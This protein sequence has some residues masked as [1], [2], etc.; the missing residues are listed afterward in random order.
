[1]QL[2]SGTH[3][4]HCGLATPQ[5]QRTESTLA[6]VMACCLTAQRHYL[7]QCW[8]IINKILWHSS[9]D[10]IMRRHFYH[11]N[12]ISRTAFRSP[13]ANELKTSWYQ[14]QLIHLLA[15]VGTLLVHQSHNFVAKSEFFI[16]I[17][18]FFLPLQMWISAM[19]PVFWHFRVIYVTIRLLNRDHFLS[20]CWVMWR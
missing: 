13:R 10:I 1:M 5:R 6:Q 2:I 12:D 9:E 15:S 3:L 11:E 16:G 17:I 20:L 19:I 4:A 14:S 18:S 8:L 7:N